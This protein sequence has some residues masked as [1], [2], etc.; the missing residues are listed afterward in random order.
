MST[1]RQCA[2]SHAQSWAGVFRWVD[3]GGGGVG[4]GVLQF[5]DHR[6]VGVGGDGQ[7]RVAEG[8]LDFFEVGSPVAEVG[9]GAVAQV[10]QPDRW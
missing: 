9:G 10:V 3:E 4:V 1:G 8:L 2:V 7:L 6:G 5:Q